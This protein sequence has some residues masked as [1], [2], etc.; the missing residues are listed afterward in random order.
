MTR[1]DVKNYLES[2]YK[3]PVASV[4]THVKLSEL[5]TV[6]TVPTIS[7]SSLMIGIILNCI[8]LLASL[9]VTYLF[10]ILIGFRRLIS[11]LNGHL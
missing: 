6:L 7:I 5:L 3:V 9:F 8:G 2:I 4:R 11:A 1:F 10:T